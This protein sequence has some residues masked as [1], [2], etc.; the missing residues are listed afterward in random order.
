MPAAPSYGRC[1]GTYNAARKFKHSRRKKAEGIYRGQ[2]TSIDAAKVR[3][4]KA[5]GM[6]ATEI[7]KALKIGRASVYRA[8]EG[9]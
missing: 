9:A 5:K 3:A 2:P 7:A 8:L 4:M 1:C 6:W